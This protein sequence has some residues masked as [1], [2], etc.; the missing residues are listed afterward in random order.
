MGPF[1]HINGQI[2]TLGGWQ[3]PLPYLLLYYTVPFL[4]LTRSLSRYNLM[5]MLGL[6]VLVSL[7]LARLT[8]PQPATRP[9][10]PPARRF[11]LPLLAAALICFEFLAAPYPLS[12][13]HIPQ[14]YFDIAAQPDRFTLAELPMN[15][16]RPTPLLHQTVHGR[17]LLTAYTSRDNPLELAWRTP[18]LQQWRT[19]G[20][21]IIDQ[22]LD[23]VASTIFYDFN[24]RY[25]VLDYWQMPPGPERDA[26]ERWVAAALPGI[27]PMYEDGRLKVYASP[28]K[29]ETVPYLSFG[30]GWGDRQEQADGFVTRTL[31]DTEQPAAELF[32][33]HPAGQSLTLE[34]SV[35]GPSETPLAIY[36]E[37]RLLDT[38]VINDSQAAYT[39]DLPPFEADLIKLRLEPSVD[40]L[41]VSRVSLTLAK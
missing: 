3:L 33:H 35:A 26:T 8:N 34:L 41:V 7:A 14:F 22:P 40:P 16:D 23:R 11:G 24:L 20:P 27:A 25:I 9:V 18:V 6:G 5:F 36:A 12:P 13:I 17:P 15:W 21:D 38:L 19:L 39:I 29:G 28:P 1:L 10:P 37:D 30:E 2:V 32:V 31:G 4:D